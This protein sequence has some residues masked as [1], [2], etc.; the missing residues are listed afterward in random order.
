MSNRYTFRAKSKKT[1]DWVYGGYSRLEDV[2]YIH[3]VVHKL[4]EVDTNYHENVLER[5]E[6]DPKTLGQC[7]GIKNSDDKLLFEGDIF[8]CDRYPFH[9]EGN[10]NY[11]G[12]AEYIDDP[13]YLGYY[14]DMIRI[15][16]RVR[17]GACGSSMTDLNGDVIDVIGNIH[18]NPEMITLQS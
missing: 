2:H 13:E 5:V 9:S 16:S 15:S 14:Y 3:C 6:I 7:I 12:V 18:D 8:K 1:N 4:I 11:V 10:L 17:G